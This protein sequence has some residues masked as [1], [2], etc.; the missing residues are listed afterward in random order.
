M[1]WGKP[2]YG[3]GQIDRAGEFLAELRNTYWSD[4]DFWT[5]E[6]AQRTQAYEAAISVVNNWRS[7]HSYPLHTMKMTPKRRARKICP[8][9]IVAQRIL[10]A[11]ER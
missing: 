2:Q 10:A 5:D 4:I 11:A 1:A 3:K 8:S 6:A 9:A 7:A